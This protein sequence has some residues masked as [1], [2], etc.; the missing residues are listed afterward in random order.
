[1][2]TRIVTDIHVGEYTV[3]VHMDNRMAATVAIKDLYDGADIGDKVSFSSD[4]AINL[5]AKGLPEDVEKF[6]E[7]RANKIAHEALCSLFDRNYER[8]QTK[9]EYLDNSYSHV[10]GMSVFVE[11][12]ER[13]IESRT[14]ETKSAC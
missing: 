1:M 2:T 8:F 5:V 10:T 7:E 11:L 14:M 3:T 4:G 6:D 12:C 13:L 9:V